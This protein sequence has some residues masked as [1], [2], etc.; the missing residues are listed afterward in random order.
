MRVLSLFDGISCAYEALVKAGIPIT[1]YHA[2]E[3]DKHAIKVSETRHPDIVHLGDVKTVQARPID[4]LIGGSPCQDLSV[5]KRGRKGLE[6]ERSG[7]FYE[8]VRLLE[9]CNPKYFI[10]ENVFSM[11]Q[12]AR[13]LITLVMGVEPI[14]I[15]A[16]LV[17]AQ[18][19]KR[20]FWTNIPVQQ[21]AD[22]NILLKDILEPTVDPRYFK[23][24]DFQ[25]GSHNG[26]RIYPTDRKAVT[27]LAS[28]GNYYR[29][30]RDIG[31]RLDEQGVRQDA[32]KTVAV[33]RRIET[34]NDDKCGTLTTVSKDNLVVGESSVRS[35]TPIECERLQCLPDGYTMGISDAQRYKCIGNAFNVEVV[36]H[37]LRG[38]KVK[39]A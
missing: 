24:A 14:M 12:E 33:Q 35:L 3:I 21:P 25:A 16:S 27:L 22:R 31:R 39:T 8:F 4:L 1:S 19:R 9:E 10:L 17:S 2:A 7:L 15:N 18:S 6:G 36:A 23:P 11:S 30:G 32:D 29:I 26:L 13:D 28:G 5:A 38:L 34:R 37:I 20:Y